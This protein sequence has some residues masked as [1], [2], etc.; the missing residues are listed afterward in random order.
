M[1]TLL[2]NG[3]Y[4][5]SQNGLPV[6]ICGRQELLQR[7]KIC[8]NVPR[9]SFLHNKDFGSRFYKFKEDQAN[10]NNAQALSMAQQALENIPQAKVIN[11]LLMFDDD[12]N[13]SAVK[14]VLN[15]E[16]I[17]EEVIVEL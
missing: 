17:A 2:E 3:D 10:A 11:A 5:V 4:K 9:G 16:N 15:I 12:K 8:L 14:V 6:S 7:V 13:I 1:D